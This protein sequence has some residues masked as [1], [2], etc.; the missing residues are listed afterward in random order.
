MADVAHSRS[1]V[2]KSADHEQFSCPTNGFTYQVP[3]VAG[4]EQ[5]ERRAVGSKVFTIAF[6]LAILSATFLW[7]A[8]L[9][10]VVVQVFF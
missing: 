10:W 3:N 6:A 7:V 1:L 5:S 4:A 8:F 2:E 9:L